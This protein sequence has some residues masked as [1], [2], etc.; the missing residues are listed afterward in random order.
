MENPEDL[1]ETGRKKYNQSVESRGV[2]YKQ[3]K[4]ESFNIDEFTIKDVDM[5]EEQKYDNPAPDVQLNKRHTF[6]THANS[7]TAS[8]DNNPQLAVINDQDYVYQSLVSNNKQEDDSDID[9]DVIEAF[10]TPDSGVSSC[11]CSV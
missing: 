6:T 8:W 7:S 3:R 11:M 5:S 1:L 10:D 9:F 2:N 4:Q